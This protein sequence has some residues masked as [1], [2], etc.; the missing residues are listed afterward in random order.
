MRIPSLSLV[1]LEVSEAII[2]ALTLGSD[3]RDF[4]AAIV[5][6]CEAVI[7]AEPE[8]T[9]QD[10]IAGDGDAG[11]TLRAGAEGE[12]FGSHRSD[13]SGVLDAMQAGKVTGQ[14]VLRDIVA[15]ADVAEE[16]MGGTSGS[17]YSI[18]FSG[19]AAAITASKALDLT[20]ESWAIA[21]DA[22]L[23]NLYK[24]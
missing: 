15:I 4:L 16:V 23:N 19:L 5:R 2:F 18:F 8:I 9:R 13:C 1:M 24:C 17:L 21:L 22:A 6:A 14:N 20:A 7:E 11:L 10:I 12:S 3:P